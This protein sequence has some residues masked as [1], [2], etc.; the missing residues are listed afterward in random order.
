[1]DAEPHD[2]TPGERPPANE[3]T[4]AQYFFCP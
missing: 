1:M 4:H 2:N 3:R